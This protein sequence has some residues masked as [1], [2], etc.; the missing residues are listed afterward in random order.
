MIS[1]DEATMKVVK[2]RDKAITDFVMNDDESAVIT[3]F[4]NYG[5]AI[6]ENKDVLRLSIWKSALE[7]TNMPQE[8]K[9][10]ATKK[11]AQWREEFEKR[12]S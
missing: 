6:P 10:A 12:N 5:I 4:L 9:D 7:I 8:V 3:Y 2:E 11:I 1:M